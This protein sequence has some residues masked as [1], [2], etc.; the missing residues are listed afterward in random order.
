[1]FSRN[2]VS[3][4]GRLG[5]AVGFA[6]GASAILA[7]DSA[8]EEVNDVPWA[9]PSPYDKGQEPGRFV[10]VKNFQHTQTVWN[11]KGLVDKWIRSD[12]EESWPWVWT[13]PNPSGPHHVFV[14]ASASVLPSC[15]EIMKNTANNITCVASVSDLEQFAPIEKYYEAGCAVIEIPVQQVDVTHKIMMLEDERI[16]CFDHAYIQ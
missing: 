14:G 3:T 1:M 9:Y 6:G 4:V 16:V 7:A 5:F 13:Q 8:T 2:M 15:K 11:L 10:D 12:G